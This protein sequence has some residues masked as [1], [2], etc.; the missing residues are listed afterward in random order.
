MEIREF[1]PEDAAGLRELFRICHGRQ[2][3]EELRRWRYE[4]HPQG[5]P[6]A[7]VAVDSGRLAGHVAAIPARLEKGDRALRAGLWIDLMVHPD[8]RNLTLF[9]DM[10]ESNRRSCMA[11]GVELLFAFPNDRSY[12]VMRRML[13]WE[14]IEEIDAMQ[15]PLSSLQGPSTTP[16]EKIDSVG[17]EFDALWS[18]LKPKDRWTQARGSAWIRWRY[19]DKPGA[20]YA[21]WAARENGRLAGWL[22]AK[23]FEGPNGRV[24][25]VLD[26]WA[27]DSAAGSLWS[28][29]LE[30][31]K[32]AGA[33]TV[34][35]WALRGDPWHA[36]FAS[37][38]L[39]ASGP[40]THFAGRWAG[41]RRSDFPEAAQWSVS[42]GDSDVF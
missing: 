33:D 20:P 34:S 23:I 3:P 16:A 18:E 42:K 19:L 36:C 41:E 35:A 5:R 15:A 25:D 40:R 32:R 30:Y 4:Q 22:A 12:P 6:Y 11:A 8:F 10:A 21:L 26:L 24:G 31:F 2:M 9:L 37:W 27:T 13:D 29:A 17:D 7:S 1:R 39:Q 38:G 14:P 28:S